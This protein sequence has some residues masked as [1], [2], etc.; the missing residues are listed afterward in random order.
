[1]LAYL[2]LREKMKLSEAIFFLRMKRPII[3]PVTTLL[4]FFFS[5][6][7]VYLV[8]FTCNLFLS[9][10]LNAFL[11][12]LISLEKELCGS[13]SVKEADFQDDYG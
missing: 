2:L 7:L 12:R 11:K 13:T 5:D 4:L 10:Q 3:N 1:V 9:L 6:S 8:L